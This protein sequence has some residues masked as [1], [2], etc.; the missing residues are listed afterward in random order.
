MAN[1]NGGK[2]TFGVGFNVDTSGLKQ[3]KQA[4][5][6]IYTAGTK[7][8]INA[9]SADQAR[10]KLTAV[11]E[12]ADKVE[13]ALMKAFNPKLD[14]INVTKFNQELSNSDLTI[15]KIYSDFSQVGAVGQRAFAS[16]AAQVYGANLNLKSA[17]NILDKIG[18]TLSNTIKWNI[19]SSIINQFSGAVQNAFNYVKALNG[20]L[21]DIRIVTGDSQEK[22][23]AFAQSANEAAASLGRQTKDYTNAYLTFVQQG[24]G[25]QDSAARTEATLKASNITGQDPSEMADNLTAVWNGYQISSE[26]AEKAVSKLAAVA[27]SSA[28]DMSELATAMSKSASVANN[29]GVTIDQL[30]AQIATITQVTRQAP[31]T[32]GNALKTIY[33]RIN[34]IK[35]G[36][37]DA[38]IS[39]GNYTK[40]MADVGISVLD[41]N[42]RLRET[43]DVMTEVGQKWSSMTREQQTYL[44]ETMAGQRQANT[45]LALFDNQ[46]TYQKE[47]NTSLEAN[48]ELNE[49]NDIYM[50]SLTAH[51][52]QLKAAQ[53][54]LIQSLADTDSFKN[55][56]DFGTSLLNIFTKLSDAIGGGGVVL[57][58]F[59][60]TLSLV[61]NKTI[62]GQINSIVTNTQNAFNNKAILQ[63]SEQMINQ[64]AGLNGI[65]SNPAVSAMQASY[66]GIA[67]YA[68]ALT[69]E[70]RNQY[71]ELLK[72]EGLL[73]QQQQDYE[74]IIA[75]AEKYA[76]QL[77]GAG[78]NIRG[79]SE[80]LVDLQ[81]QIKDIT[82][83]IEKAKDAANSITFK[84]GGISGDS[85]KAIKET[86]QGIDLSS[87]QG[88]TSL[89]P[90]VQQAVQTLDDVNSN[91]IP[92]TKSHL[93]D[94]Q[95]ALNI[96]YKYANQAGAALDID[97][98]NINKK[99]DEQD[100][101]LGKVN[102]A[103]EGIQKEAEQ[104][105]LIQNIVQTTAAIGQLSSSGA[106]LMNIFSGLNDG[107]VD[108]T[109]AISGL[110]AMIP[111]LIS[112]FVALQA[113]MG[114]IGLVLGAISTAIPFV[115]K[116]ID[117]LHTSA[118]EA[119]EALKESTDE[120]SSGLD[121]FDSLN[122]QL[123]ETTN[124]INEI[125]SKG[126]ISITDAQDLVNLKAQNAE[127]EAEIKN[128]E[129]LNRINAEATNR[130]TRQAFKSGT[131][132]MASND[133]NFYGTDVDLAKKSAQ[134]N[135]Q[136]ISKSGADYLIGI[137]QFDKKAEEAF[138]QA[139]KTANNG[140]VPKEIQANIDE[141]EKNY[142][143]TLK[144]EADKMSQ[145]Q[146]ALPSAL[147]TQ[148]K[149]LIKQLKDV[150]TQYYKNSGQLEDQIANAWS[151]TGIDIDKIKEIQKAV[152]ELSEDGKKLDENSLKDKIGTDAFN[153]LKAI[154]DST[155]ISIETLTS[156]LGDLDLS[157]VKVG[158]DTDKTT[159]KMQNQADALST[160]VAGA[161]DAKDALESISKGNVLGEDDQTALNTELDALLEKYPQL[162]QDVKTVRE[163][164]NDGVDSVY[165]YADAMGNIENAIDVAKLDQ[166]R[167]D[168][169]ESAQ[170]LQS[171]LDA[172]TSDDGVTIE[173]ND[174]ALKYFEDE[175]DNY[176]N[177][178]HVI[179]VTVNTKLDE[180]V[181]QIQGQFDSIAG[182]ASKIGDNFVVAASDLDALSEA[183]P[184]ILQGM[185][186]LSDGSYQLN[187]DI[188]NNAIGA[189]TAETTANAESVAAQI[190]NNIAL[191]EDKE[192]QYRAIAA[193]AQAMATNEV[194]SDSDA[195][196]AKEQISNAVKKIRVD[197]SQIA[198]N[199]Q[200]SDQQVVANDSD[201]KGAAIAANYA[202]AASSASQ[203]VAD[204]A[205]SSIRSANQVGQ[206]MAN[207]AKAM[208]TGKYTKTNASASG[209]NA[210]N[211]YKGTTTQKQ[212]ASNDIGDLTS[213]SAI[214]SYLSKFGNT[215]EGYQ[216]LANAANA[217]ADAIAKNIAKQR[218]S[219]TMLGASA[220]GI[221]KGL[222]NIGNGN[223]YAPSSKSGKSGNSGKSGS[224]NGGNK[225]SQKQ[226]KSSA[227][228]LK[229]WI[230]DSDID[231]YHK[232]NR[233][234]EDLD[235][236]IN[237]I[238]KDA[239]KSTRQGLS[240]NLDREIAALE[241]EN[242][243]YQEKE[244][245]LRQDMAN[246]K[247]TAKQMGVQFDGQNNIINYT[248]LEI[249]HQQKYNGLLAEAAKTTDA[250]AQE[251]I[252]N[253]A[254]IEKS[255]WDNLKKVMD[256]YEDLQNTLQDTEDKVQ[257][258]VDKETELKIQQFKIDIDLQIEV[259]EAKRDFNKFRKEV[260][261]K[262]K[263]DDYV[264]QAKARLQ[265]FFSYYD[266]T[267][268]GEI[269]KLSDKVNKIRQEAQ[270]IENGGTSSIY[271]K[272]EKSAL[273]DL[274]K[275]NDELM[276]NLEDAQE[277]VEDIHK[278]YLDTIDKAKEMFDDQ[279]SAYDQVDK[280]IEHD[281]NLITLLHGDEDYE[282]LG[283]WYDQR[284]QNYNQEIDF[285]RKQAD[286][287]KQ[288][289]D[290]A[291]KGTDEWKKFRDNWMSSITDLN[292]AV[293]NAV[294]NLLDKYNNTINKIIKNTKDQMLGG[295][296]NKALDQWDR[297]KWNDNRYL[298]V[299]SRATGVLDF[300]DSVNSAM[301]KQSPRVQKQLSEFMD[302]E[303]DDLNNIANLRQID[304]DIANKKLEVLQ[305]QIALEDIQNAKTNMRLR[306]DSQGNYTYQYVADEDQVQS[307]QSDLRDSL[308]ELRKLA[309]ED[310]SDT[311]DEVQDK[312]QDFF[313]KAAEL[314]Q[315]YYDDQEVLQ[316]KLLELQEEYFGEDG[317]IT[318]L[319]VDYNTMQSQLIELTGAEFGNLLA[320]MGDNLKAFLGLNGDEASDDSVW[321]SIQ[322]LMGEDG[323]IPTL[324]DAFVNEV[325]Q[326]NFDNMGQI[327]QD[328]LFGSDTGLS[329]SWNTALGQVGESY[330]DLTNNVIIPAMN[331]IIQANQVYQQDLLNLQSV[332]GVVFTDIANGV[333][334]DI[335]Q[336][337]GL[338]QTNEALIQTMEDEVN[339]AA[340]VYS[341]I[342]SLVNAYQEAEAAAIQAAQAANDFWMAATGAN[343]VSSPHNSSLPSGTAS[344]VPT[345]I[346]NSSG[347]G[348]G[349]G[350][351]GG[352]AGAANTSTGAPTSNSKN[353][354]KV[355]TQFEGYQNAY[356]SSGR[357]RGTNK[358]G[359][360]EYFATGGY[361]GEWVNGNKEGKLAFLHQ[362]ELVLNKDDT[363]NT[364]SAVKIARDLISSLSSVGG[365]LLDKLASGNTF[366]NFATN[367]NSSTNQDITINATFPDVQSSQ[368][369]EKAFNNLVN[370]ATQ[371]A[372]KNRRAY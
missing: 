348:G 121:N 176:I 280:L 31:E 37:D 256:C 309:K 347:S 231:R 367:S 292:S 189:A 331:S 100:T 127:L 334:Y 169:E 171:I 39:L 310:V 160:I 206:A 365:N 217:A 282:D 273:D 209:I 168:A 193:A 304:L 315:T 266:K 60:S 318:K 15:E 134:A 151:G 156:G 305:K 11:E 153:N 40:K 285:Y 159:D 372:Q 326:K 120:Y 30:A 19:S 214:D 107:T 4:L 259:S 142:E 369:I 291:K 188:V 144:D 79:N 295:D 303:V 64:I 130:A 101:A 355:V 111:T 208:T 330:I 358:S 8:I 74:N 352:S 90:E 42:G 161:K 66:E 43:G 123:D 199:A 340:S 271:G 302:K 219:L 184:G 203:S 279:V 245:L 146:E 247:A 277:I 221:A 41:A 20:S 242:G 226:A 145:A 24:M 338:I 201:T 260:I 236:N 227:D 237:H 175:L 62:A 261:N 360:W 1:N 308:E 52:N 166:T 192:A 117:S 78:S 296:W 25:A 96:T 131:F 98:D 344:Q 371:R 359:K 167:E 71:N 218:D 345:G 179:D 288:Q 269:Q 216:N 361:T 67:K 364:L 293:E 183:F 232:L 14:S 138:V 105:S 46:A 32:T 262:I 53:E 289:M 253:E 341:E 274:K 316:E 265:D 106:G 337:Q 44:A 157:L 185:Q 194:T 80:E 225:G 255:R 202:S 196:K 213:S 244:K 234:L 141:W 368:E 246:A 272:D 38:E 306:R 115:V 75:K 215:S 250:T 307:A 195:A 349:G 229:D 294:Q 10:D 76:K 200:M 343:V 240:A 84:S 290:N 155:G 300:V 48:N 69:N 172:M 313:D 335:G 61:F 177:A 82:K 228:I 164:M 283:N 91:K 149:E 27:D 57:A 178:E 366:R 220:N 9:K 2:I 362:K 143:E 210:S 258:I 154:S 47:L 132:D 339:A 114:P 336:T 191:M 284:A 125:Q 5:N 353:S 89:P 99:L 103:Q 190:E 87:L 33:M 81:I 327:N 34:D 186:E 122:T 129:T 170:Q 317:Y 140:E 17:Q 325:Y 319:G 28:S 249:E 182:A 264:G 254:A 124:K 165:N 21:N 187:E 281:M 45:L 320:E 323:A 238:E 222:T 109:G 59:A 58:N 322:T 276:N 239:D 287:W 118:K 268:T 333:D 233:E 54:G 198:S 370:A 312:L 113:A 297:A 7:S 321:A 248:Q 162:A 77:N 174:E 332:A 51:T 180:A 207:A 197:D 351:S 36:A 263:D 23:D 363:K 314:S 357:L 211:T 3:V 257:D 85:K 102:A 108:A 354:Y 83:E 126:T 147:A 95:N 139:V 6:A 152:K 328:F 275:Y 299:A 301:N 148:D 342:Q 50:E 35:A 286:M 68:S 204:W 112:G 26:N 278:N 267:G 72:Q 56:I 205:N 110:A 252:L 92:V 241:K 163:A 243:L 97:I 298:D 212:T 29:M 135:G 16:I 251:V 235:D 350:A 88:N 13:R 63:Q 356:D 73:V 270:I 65:S 119:G 311:I 86:I 224:G 173:I 94:I 150:I 136:D 181:E 116:G 18:E 346:N 55:V 223:A 22:M 93:Q 324:F 49:K 329:P 137:G 70:Q 133:Q 128:Q 158:E 230:K 104:Q 12:T